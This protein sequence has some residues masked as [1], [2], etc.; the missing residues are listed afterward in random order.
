MNHHFGLKDDLC[1]LQAQRCA[2][3][4]LHFLLFISELWF[5]KSAEYEIVLEFN[6]YVLIFPGSIWVQA[7]VES[8]YEIKYD[9]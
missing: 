9:I 5:I 4:I 3:K 7:H 8:G 6:S 1:A 2:K